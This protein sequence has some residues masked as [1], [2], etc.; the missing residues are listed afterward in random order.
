MGALHPAIDNI[1]SHP[2]HIPS[3]AYQKLGKARDVICEQR[4]IITEAELSLYDIYE[5]HGE[6]NELLSIAGA[7]EKTA[8]H[9]FADAIMSACREASV[10]PQNAEKTGSSGA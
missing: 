8:S 2:Y 4:G 7:M 6:K 9:P 1:S 10:S 5:V 3:F